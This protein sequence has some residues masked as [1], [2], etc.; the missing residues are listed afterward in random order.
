MTIQLDDR[1]A[2]EAIACPYLGVREDPATHCTF[3]T[4]AHRCA[5]AGG[6]SRIA[7][8][9]QLA[10]CLSGGHRHC[11]VILGEAK[12]PPPDVPP[13][14]RR[15][16]AWGAWILAVSLVLA[17][18]A[19]LHAASS[20]RGAEHAVAATIPA[21]TPASEPTAPAVAASAGGSIPAASTPAPTPVPPPPARYEVQVGDTLNDIAAFFGARPQDVIALNH[22]PPDGRI[23]A[24]QELV[25][26]AGP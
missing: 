19:V 21:S 5:Y 26:P 24:G 17:L 4:A 7:I 1:R 13:S 6:P 12:L 16:A 2:P 11:P 18:A 23:L 8:D 20:H 9:H 15:R 14:V 22:L 25:I 10:F 3:A